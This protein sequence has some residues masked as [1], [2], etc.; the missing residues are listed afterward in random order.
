MNNKGIQFILLS[1]LFFA[2]VNTGVK[3]LSNPIYFGFQKFP[4]HQIV[5]IRS[6]ISFFISYYFLKKNKL[7]ILGVNKKWL[8]I[9][10]IF[11]T[12]ALTLFFFTLQ[13]LNLAIATVLQYLSPIFTILIS[14]YFFKEKVLKMQWLMIAISFVGVIM[15]GIEKM[16]NNHLDLFWLGMGLLSAGFS[17]IAYNAIIQCRNTDSPLNIVIY[18][19][20]LAAPVMGIWCLYEFVVPNFIELF[21]LIL[22]GLFT[23]FAQ[24]FMTKAL[25]SANASHIVPFKYLGAIYAVF[26]GYFIFDEKLSNLSLMAMGVIIFGLLGNHALKIVKKQRANYRAKKIG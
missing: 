8:L 14:M 6:V 20:M 24:V 2:L 9:R 19:P 16:Q 7:P 5:F 12:L 26:L 3:T 4:P 15:L 25:H 18:F 21:I 1:T 11:G 17:G 22:I 10:G 13:H 23:Q